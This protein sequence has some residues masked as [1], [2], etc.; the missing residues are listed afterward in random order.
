M[1]IPYRTYDSQT[2]PYKDLEQN[3]L[4]AV[5]LDL[6]I[7]MQYTKRDPQFNE[8]LKFAGKPI[9]PGFYV[10]VFRKENEALAAQFDA[11][12][13]H[14]RANG[15]LR[16]IYES[17]GLVERRPGRLWRRA[18][19]RKRSTLRPPSGLLPQFFPRL[20]RRGGDDRLP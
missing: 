1:G 8:K 14:L 11:A 5:L 15:T 7:A 16:K 4:D 9:S 6:P 18:S 20:A 3:Q 10:M 2:T 19:S 17:L 12:I 13:E